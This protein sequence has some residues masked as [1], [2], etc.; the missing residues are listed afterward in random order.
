MNKLS[1]EEVLVIQMALS[2]MI[3][4]TEAIATDQ[5]IPL[6]PEARAQGRQ[7]L[8]AAKSA[9]AKVSLASGC[10]VK[11]DPYEDGDELDFLTKQS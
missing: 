9:H 1:P 8:A 4:D 2:A 3:E 10:E 7:I 11:L 5:S 6:T